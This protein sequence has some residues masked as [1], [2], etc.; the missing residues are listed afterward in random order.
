MA[1]GLNW[2]ELAYEM[3]HPMLHL[4]LC[5]IKKVHA[6]ACTF[7]LRLSYPNYHLDYLMLYVYRY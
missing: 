5:R 3:L 4:A 6:R 7:T 1:N 2:H